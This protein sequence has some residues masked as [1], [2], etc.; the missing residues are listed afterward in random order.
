MTHKISVALVGAGSMGGA[1]LRGWLAKGL[2][3]ARASAVFEPFPDD[4]LA[5]A[6]RA[7]GIS[8]NPPADGLS[9][10]A[11][12]IAVKPQAA[13]E[14]LPRFSKAAESAVIISVMAGRSI[15][16]VARTLSGAAQIVRAM[17]NLPAAVGAG[18][19]ALY[20]SPDVTAANRAIAERLMN[21]V[22][23]VI[24]V[25]SE[26]A[27]DAA[28]AVSGNGPAYFFLLGEAL[29][30]AGRSLGLPEDAAARLARA[31]L[32]GA[33]AY[34]DSDT[35]ALSGLRRAVTS[36]GGTTEAALSV[37]DGDDKAIR[38]L[39]IKAVEAARK[40]AGELTK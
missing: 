38:R 25:E 24:W 36:P 9:I 13:D 4:R 32:V 10:D 16:S 5:G 27:I 6:A 17:P 15:A 23:D 31:T 18:A 29:A 2:I 30:E 21:A 22:G 40:R 39:M 35:R 20:A 8:L 7:N 11:L 26:A 34:A 37:L 14:A 1:L 3:D 28:T 12:I 19:T 33:G